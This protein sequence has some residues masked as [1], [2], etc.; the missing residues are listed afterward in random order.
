MLKSKDSS[1]RVSVTNHYYNI[2][3]FVFWMNWQKIPLCKICLHHPRQQ[4][5]F[6]GE[7]WQ[8]ILSIALYIMVIILGWIAIFAK[9]GRTKLDM[10]LMS[11]AFGGWDYSLLYI[12]RA[13]WWCVIEKVTFLGIF[14]IKSW[15]WALAFVLHHVA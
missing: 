2:D 9:I 13:P 8:F 3:Q 12:L 4:R 10:K 11:I 6:F 14:S 15:K 1:V 5:V 7:T